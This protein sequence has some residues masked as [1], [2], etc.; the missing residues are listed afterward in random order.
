MARRAPLIALAL[1]FSAASGLSSCVRADSYYIVGD[2]R[3]KAE[4]GALFG[5]LDTET[6]PKRR[7]LVMHQLF[8]T[9][10]QEG[11]GQ[12]LRVFLPAYVSRHAED[13]YAAYYLYLAAGLF[14]EAQ[15]AQ[16]AAFYYA[17]AL[18]D[19][20]DLMVAGESTHLRCLKRLV[21][22]CK[23]P[24]L[25][26]TYYKDLIARFPDK[27]DEATVY[28]LLGHSYEELG[29]WD[30]AIQNYSKFLPLAETTTVIPGYPDA[31]RTAKNMVDYYRSSKSWTM[32]DLGQLVAKVQ[33]GLRARDS[34]ALRQYIAQVNF[35]AKSWEQQENDTPNRADFN[36]GPFFGGE[37]NKISCAD[38]LEPTS[39]SREAF[40]KTWGWASSSRIS[41]WYFYFRKIYF[42]ADPEIHGRWEWAGI[43]FGEKH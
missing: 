17:R 10:Y 39:N 27:I 14:E 24:E 20:T 41:T 32:E 29:E 42:P 16:A 38:Q 3:Q 33:A 6:D 36:F 30:L 15:E 8:S 4:L 43:Y 5:Y 7:Y 37:G 34:G 21:I 19:C 26:V 18:S 13:P 22:L 9:L 23:S 31:F 40:L 2:S 25:K 28:Y 1:L 12:R 35:F 11:Q